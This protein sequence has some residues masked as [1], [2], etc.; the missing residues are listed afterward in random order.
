MPGGGGC[1]A[2]WVAAPP[3]T[4]P[5][6]TD[7]AHRRHRRQA[8]RSRAYRHRDN[9]GRAQEHHRNRGRPRRPATE[10]GRRTRRQG[11]AEDRSRPHRA[12]AGPRARRPLA[13]RAAHPHLCMTGQVQSRWPGWSG[14]GTAP[15]S[16]PMES[17]HVRQL[18]IDGIRYGERG[19]AGPGHRQRTCGQTNSR[20]SAAAPH[21]PQPRARWNER[22]IP[23]LWRVSRRRA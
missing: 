18:I 22:S 12:R 15:G 8:P 7:R 13:V 17:D 2:G 5:P 11:R 9:P 4:R 10:P 16:L 19:A 6:T 3:I 1:R 14:P 21:G 20:Q 23:R